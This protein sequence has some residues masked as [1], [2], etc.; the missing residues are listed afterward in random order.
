MS[1]SKMYLVSFGIWNNTLKPPQNQQN[2]IKKDKISQIP[3]NNVAIKEDFNFY[4]YGSNATIVYLKEY[5][6]TTF[7]HKY[8]KCC[9]CLLSLYSVERRNYTLLLNDDNTKKLS[10]HK[11]DKLFLIK[12]NALCDCEFK[13]YNQYMNMSKFDLIS[14]I[15][16]LEGLYQIV[17][18][19]FK[20]LEDS[21]KI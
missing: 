18:N 21:N 10:L 20:E 11:N 4:D 14:K 15:K 16:E 6:L 9:K 13:M 2:D 12:V 1:V 19:N 8:D 17:N 5:F 7:G 3:V